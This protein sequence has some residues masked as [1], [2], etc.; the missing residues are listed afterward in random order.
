M[1]CYPHVLWRGSYFI[2]NDSY[3]NLLT[4]YLTVCNSVYKAD[5]KKIFQI[6][7][8]NRSTYSIGMSNKY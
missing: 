6:E 1:L 2:T 7:K 5:E 8:Q 3:L 4:L